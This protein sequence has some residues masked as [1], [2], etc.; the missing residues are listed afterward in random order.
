MRRAVVIGVAIVLLGTGPARVAEA[1]DSTMRTIGYGAG[2]AF[3]TLVYAPL[4]T[5]FCILGGIGSGF[6]LIFDRG[7]APSAARGP[8]QRQVEGAPLAGLG[9]RPGAAGV[10]HGD[11]PDDGQ[12]DA[13]ARVLLLAVEP[14][15]DAEDPVVVLHVEARALIGDR[16][17]DLAR[18]RLGT[19]G[20]RPARPAA[21]PARPAP[22]ASLVAPAASSGGDRR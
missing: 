17:D 15:E 11:L 9:L 4:K 8:G 2:S 1:Q 16:E 19:H 21:G 13:G 7:T 3:G 12:P 14:L 20:D 22:A 10:P 18:A 6:T 5:S